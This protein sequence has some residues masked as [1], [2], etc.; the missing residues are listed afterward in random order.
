MGVDSPTIRPTRV[1]P[2]VTPCPS[3]IGL[4]GQTGPRALLAV[5]P[6]LEVGSLDKSILCRH[7]TDV[8]GLFSLIVS[9]MKIAETQT[10]FSL[11]SNET[12]FPVINF[13]GIFLFKQNIPSA[14]HTT[15]VAFY[16]LIGSEDLKLQ[17]NHVK[18]KLSNL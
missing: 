8:D 5:E 15:V 1:P 18:I 11:V 6:P 2:R 4:H 10:W 7:T 14:N 9:F 17:T 12:H 3:A 16:Y 13:P